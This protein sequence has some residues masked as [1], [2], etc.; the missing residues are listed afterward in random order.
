[1]LAHETGMLVQ[2]AG[3]IRAGVGAGKIVAPVGP[4]ISP[5]H[6]FQR[7][8]VYKC[9]GT[10]KFSHHHTGYLNLKVK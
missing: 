9:A 4:E 8:S 2:E 3:H 1:M 7:T 10:N 6:V 5:P